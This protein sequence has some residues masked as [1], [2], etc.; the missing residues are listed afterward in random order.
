MLI[1]QKE[2]GLH[3]DENR[4]YFLELVARRHLGDTLSKDEELYLEE[5]EQD[6][7]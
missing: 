6:L 1:E 7:S 2:E 4:L 5:A 3:V